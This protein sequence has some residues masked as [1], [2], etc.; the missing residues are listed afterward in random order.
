[1]AH[2]ITAKQ[3]RYADNYIETGNKYQSAIKAGYSETY[4]RSHVD[5]LSENVGIKSY[6]EERMKEIESEKIAKQDEVLKFYT[7]VLRGEVEEMIVVGTKDGADFMERP[8]DVKTRLSAAKELLKRYPGN[9]KLTE[10]QIRK[11]KAEARI[12]EWKA[13]QLEGDGEDNPIIAAISQA[14]AQRQESQEGD[15]HSEN[16]S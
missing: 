9:D 15:K 7:S 13:D 6:I 4:A 1:M 12:A 11:L 16:E 10:Q 5:K 14:L 3:Q 8:P 2:K